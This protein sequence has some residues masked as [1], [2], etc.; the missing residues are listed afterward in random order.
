MYKNKKIIA[1]IPARANS[2][3]CPGKNLR[4]IKGKPMISWTIEAAIN[5]KFL[6]KI[7]VTSDDPN[8]LEIAESYDGVFTINRPDHLATDTVESLD[9]VLHALDQVEDE[10]YYGLLLQPT[11]PLRI[12]KDIDDS[13]VLCGDEGAKTCVSY[14]ELP[15]PSS[16]Y[17]GSTMS[18]MES[19]D[20]Y[21]KLYRANGAIYLFETTY[22]KDKK[23]FSDLSTLPYL[24]PED[25]SVDV[26]TEEDFATA[27]RLAGDLV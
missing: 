27:K 2:K 13:I 19:M 20:K 23:I 21:N 4:L 25:R 5:S 3:R 26:D 6:D 22:L 14:T 24:M 7:V 1:I 10:Y 17:C 16:F 8:I 12:P 15:K 11:S 9:V 18:G